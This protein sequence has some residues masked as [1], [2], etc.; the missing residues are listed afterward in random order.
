MACWAES[1]SALVAIEFPRFQILAQE[2]FF[3]FIAAGNLTWIPPHV[4][5]DESLVPNINGGQN[6]G[7]IRH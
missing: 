2:R 5:E 6:L 4:P 3:E 7:L 1:S